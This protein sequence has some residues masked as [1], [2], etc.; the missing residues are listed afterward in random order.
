MTA[1]AEALDRLRLGNQRFVSNACERVNDSPVYKRE[2][3][4]GGQKPFAIVVGCSDSRVPSEIIFDQGLGDLF[5]IRVA[6]NIVAPTQLGSIEYAAAHLGPRLIVVLG[7]SNCGA[8]QGTINE[9][10]H[11]GEGSSPNID[12]ILERIRPVVEPLVEKSV[13]K[14]RAELLRQ[15]VRANVRASI[16][17]IHTGSPIVEDLVRDSG[18][19]IVGADYSLATGA[20]D[21]FDGLPL[22]G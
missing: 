21:F 14:D 10:E 3:L 17:H 15:A 16:A 12:S 2:S 5:V 8:I 22:S 19:R 13:G 4:L 18:L 9:L 1:A 7:H 20:V 11:P 6:G